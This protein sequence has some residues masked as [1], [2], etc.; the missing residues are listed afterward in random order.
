[1]ITEFVNI[2]SIAT[3]KPVKPLVAMTGEISLTGKV[4][5]FPWC[6]YNLRM[7][8][9]IRSKILRYNS[10]SCIQ[11]GLRVYRCAYSVHT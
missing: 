8:N 4:G 7:H 6:I 10:Y 5:L 9:T 3:G 2:H 1:M 11:Y